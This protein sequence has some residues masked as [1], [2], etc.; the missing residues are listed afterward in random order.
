MMRPT[1]CRALRRR[2]GLSQAG[3]ARLCGVAR[4]SVARWETSAIRIPPLAERL[5]RAFAE[6]HARTGTL[7]DWE[8]PRGRAST[9]VPAVGRRPRRRNRL[10]SLR[11][12]RRG[13]RA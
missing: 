4:V 3:L 12:Q 11:F 9:P 10:R 5:L 6:A 7:P 1:E 8:H 2:L 13:D